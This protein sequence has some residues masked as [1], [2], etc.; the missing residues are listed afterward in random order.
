MMARAHVFLLSSTLLALCATMASAEPK[1]LSKQYPRC[2]SCHY[3]PTGGG[4][5]TTYGRSLSHRELSTFGEPMPSHDA[6][7]QRDTTNPEPGEESFLWGAFGKSLGAL[8]LGIETRPSYLHYSFLNVSDD[9][10]LLMNADL[11]AAYQYKDWI[12]YGQ[13]GRELQDD[14]RFSLDSS[15]YWIGRRPEEGFGFRAGRFLPAYGIRFADHTSYNREFL[16]LAQ[17]DQI[18][19]VEVSH[20]RGRYLTQV[21]VGPG[22]AE[23]VYDDN[24]DAA[25]TA[26][27][28]FQID[29]TPR[30]VVAASGLFRDGTDFEARQGSTG[31]A[32][33]YAPTSRVATWT[34]FD[35]QFVD[36]QDSTSYVFVN[37]TSFEVYRGI[38]A[39]V[40]PQARVGGGDQIPDLLRLGLGAVLLPRTHFNVNVTYYRDRDRSSDVTSNIFLAQFHLYL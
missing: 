13:V 15:E 39:V 30:T 32:F 16:G 3:S 14:G 27:G 8:Q 26:T 38:W 28:R 36:G 18:L 11:H 25:F 6:A 10:N 40:S 37:E 35:G 9:R 12:F 23:R 34:Q 5:L 19:G 31:L 2:T 22:R 29:L 4:L 20:S 17:Y 24:G 21:S 7:A 33:G 1:F